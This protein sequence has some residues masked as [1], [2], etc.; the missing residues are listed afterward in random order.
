MSKIVYNACYGGF[1]LSKKALELARSLA[2]NTPAWLEKY[3]ED[4]IERHD[5]ILVEIVELLGKEAGGQCSD[6]RIAELPSGTMYRIDSYDGMEE[7]ATPEDYKWK[8]V[9]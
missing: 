3:P 1:S 5:L 6:L 7:V 9:P 8:I 4:S 2:P